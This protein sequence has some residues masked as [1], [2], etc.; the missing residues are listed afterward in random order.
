MEVK[1]PVLDRE[2]NGTVFI[3]DLDEALFR[4]TVVGTV[5]FS[6]KDNSDKFWGSDLEFSAIMTTS[7]PGALDNFFRGG[8]FFRSLGGEDGVV[9]HRWWGVVM[10]KILAGG[11]S[12]VWFE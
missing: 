5:F 12:G 9:D 1:D 4:F 3:T 11:C 6:I 2:M 10:A 7:G 8:R